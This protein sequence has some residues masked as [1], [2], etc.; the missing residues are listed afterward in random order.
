MTERFPPD[1]P[2]PVPPHW[3]GYRVVPVAWEFWAGR[4]GR[5]HD[6]LRYVRPAGS[7]G[8]WTRDRLAP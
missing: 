2:V 1:A 6:R 4:A 3:G 8:P 7:T 5:M